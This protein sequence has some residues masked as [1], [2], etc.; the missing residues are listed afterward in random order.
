MREGQ[1]ANDVALYLADGDAWASFMP[2]NVAMNAAV[3]SGWDVTSFRGSWHRATTSISSTMAC[4]TLRGKV[5]GGDT[6]LRRREVQGRGAGRRRAHSAVDDPQTGGVCQRRRHPIATRRIPSLAPGFKATEEDQKTVQ[7]TAQRL[8]KD[9]QRAGLFIESD[10][11]LGDA[12]AKRLPPDFKIE[13]AAPEIGFVH[14]K[15]DSGD[16]YFLAN[17]GNTP[18]TSRRAS[19]STTC[20]R[21]DGIR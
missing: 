2:G 20:S 6:G 19:A 3:S 17:T 18:K 10:I 16:I 21:S 5:D 4:S 1:P 11:G 15:T 7:E 13:P 14:R 9:S 12:L 8:F